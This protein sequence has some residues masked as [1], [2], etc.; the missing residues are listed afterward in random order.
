M[1]KRPQRTKVTSMRLTDEE[2]AELSALAERLGIDLS[3][4]IRRAALS[5]TYPAPPTPS[6]A[7][8]TLS[9]QLVRMNWTAG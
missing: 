1:S 2:H 6:Q 9:A 3:E 8:Y 5:L 4:L 7:T